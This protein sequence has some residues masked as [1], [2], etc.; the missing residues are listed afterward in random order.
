MNKFKSL[1]KKNLRKIFSVIIWSVFVVQILLSYFE[2]KDLV[3]G[4]EKE[5]VETAISRVVVQDEMLLNSISRTALTISSDISVVK[6]FHNGSFSD[7]EK[8]SVGLKV[9]KYLSIVDNIDKVYIYSYKYDA[10]YN[11]NDF[12]YYNDDNIKNKI[13]NIAEERTNNVFYVHEDSPLT[14]DT[15]KIYYLYC[16]DNKTN[17]MIIVTGSVG[18]DE[19]IYRDF[20]NETSAQLIV[21]DENA[22]VLKGNGTYQIGTS[23]AQEDIFKKREDGQ[24]KKF[25][26]SG[27]EKY[28]YRYSE[29]TRRWY[30]A[31]L[32]PTDIKILDFFGLRFSLVFVSLFLSVILILAVIVYFRKIELFTKKIV[33]NIGN[34][35]KHIENE[36]R[37]LVTKYKRNGY[38]AQTEE[39]LVKFLD[40]NLSTENIVMLIVKLDNYSELRK[41]FD[42]DELNLYSYGITNIIEELLG[43]IGL[44][45]YLLE[46]SFGKI[47]FLVSVENGDVWKDRFHVF[48]EDVSKKVYEYISIKTSSFST[49]P[50]CI[51]DVGSCIQKS[52]ELYEYSYIYTDEAIICENSIIAMEDEDFIKLYNNVT[53]VK[54]AVSAELL[55]EIFNT[56]EKYIYKISPEQLRKIHLNLSLNLYFALNK[57]LRNRERV[58]KCMDVS[59]MVSFVENAE[60]YRA[61]NVYLMSILKSAEIP[62]DEKNNRIYLMVEKC[63]KIIDEEYSKETICINE[64]AD[65]LG[66]SV[67]YFG[68][69]FKS[70]TGKSVN[71]MILEK[72]LSEA[73][74]LLLE[75][76]LSVKK[77]IACVGMTN[78][79]YFAAVFKKKY[80][81]SPLNYRKTRE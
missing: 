16:I 18:D 28:Y 12:C 1:Y 30:I 29:F 21:V 14:K 39:S 76:N 38:S 34:N 78:S 75:T 5:N 70:V 31:L 43:N 20:D 66:M 52:E 44:Q 42:L 26:V 3:F 7:A 24:F 65:R 74:R 64:I 49:D 25:S 58:S 4:K 19:S 62:D 71:E 6:F 41:T 23:I 47:T 32:K 67:N 69:K 15:G 68:R 77:I 9:K 48:A 56:I 8:M 80:G 35:K 63:L 17:D 13:R 2:Y 33:T 55:D 61:V 54:Q 72:R 22:N 73:E 11:I 57:V 45:G 10:L 51:T 40:E 81:V 27:N 59:E 79:S 36:I 46:D 53:T 50:R 37:R 60:S